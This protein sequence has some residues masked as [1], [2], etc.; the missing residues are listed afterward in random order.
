MRPGMVLSSVRLVCC[1]LRMM[2]Q[3]LAGRV[4]ELR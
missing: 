1:V 2:M 4:F 3:V